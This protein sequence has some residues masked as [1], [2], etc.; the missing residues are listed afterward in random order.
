MALIATELHLLQ[1][2]IYELIIMRIAFVGKGGSG[3]TTM[4]ALFSL[5]VKEENIPLLVIDADINM[6]LPELL[7]IQEVF[8]KEM[9]ISHPDAVKEIKTHLKGHNTRIKELSHFRKTTPPTKE[10]NLIFINNKEDRII[11]SFSKKNGNLPLMIVGTYDSDDIGASCYHNNLSIFEN[12]LS[13]IVDKDEFV[14][15]DMVAGVDAFANTLHAQFD[16]LVLVVE[17]TKRGVEVFEQY[18]ELALSA[19]IYDCLFIVGNKVRNVSDQ[20]FIADH[21]PKEKLL[22]SLKES[23]YLRTKDQEGGQL[24]ITKLEPENRILFE[25]IFD[26]LRNTSNSNQDR[27][28]K[29]WDLHRT[30]VAQDFIKERFGDLTNQIDETFN[31]NDYIKE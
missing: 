16:L 22:G 29:L 8:P 2:T 9:H 15:T 26:K 4:S 12:I 5:L 28:K 13:H 3:K 6:H 11:N 1:I 23:K 18:K 17:P 31:F 21:I 27:L 20:K 25:T 10:S 14:I 24:D 19:G 30:Y 7:G